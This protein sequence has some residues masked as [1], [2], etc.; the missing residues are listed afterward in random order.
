M[1]YEPV[2]VGDDERP[3][4]V[5]LWFKLYSA[6]LSFIYLLCVGLSFVF[7]LVDPAKLEMDAVAAKVTGA[8]MLLVGLGLFAACLLPLVLAQRPWLWIYDLVIICFGF[9]SVCFWPICIPLLI[10]WLKP[11]TKKYFGS[12]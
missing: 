9:T 12:R 4:G 8:V 11:E 3:P 7:L 6:F 1:T 10:F 2:F 5:I